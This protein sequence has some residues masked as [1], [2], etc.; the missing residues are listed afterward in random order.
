MS[1]PSQRSAERGSARR[2]PSSRTGTKRTGRVASAA[3]AVRERPSLTGR[4]VILAS[5]VVILVV[6][7]AV[8]VRELVHQ[9]GEINALRAEN[10]AAQARV[11]DL[12]IRE[13][14]L[15]DPAYV[16]SLVRERL[17]YLLPGEIGYVVLD[18]A[19]APAPA[20]AAKKAASLSWYEGLWASVGAVDHAVAP[21]VVPAYV[22]MRPDAPR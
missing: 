6:T 3:A 16:V 10:A 7:L 12:L 9:R 1:G 11:D 15:K 22:P 21:A 19:E 4:A 8:P 18:P 2:A 20:P 14:R 13:Q 17:H 5:V